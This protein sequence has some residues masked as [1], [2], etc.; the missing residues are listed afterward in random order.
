MI[1]SYCDNLKGLFAEAVHFGI[2]QEE[3]AQCF[4]VESFIEPGF[5]YLATGAVILALLNT[6]TNKAVYQYFRDRDPAV[7]SFRDTISDSGM[8]NQDSDEDHD[9]ESGD[10]GLSARIQPVPVSFTDTFRWMLHADPRS[11]V[12]GGVPASSTRELF[13]FG[14]GDSF[15]N[16]WDLPEAKAV[17]CDPDEVDSAMILPS[18]NT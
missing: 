10:V 12:R 11:S 15:S 13:G 3:D 18:G 17:V 16:H 7:K 1:N 6:F 4:A 2:L 8:T 9:S 14:M 5:F